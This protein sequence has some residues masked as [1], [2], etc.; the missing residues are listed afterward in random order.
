MQVDSFVIN[1]KLDARGD[2]TVPDKPEFQVVAE[3][4]FNTETRRA[5]NNNPAVT[6]EK[7]VEMLPIPKKEIPVIPTPNVTNTESNHLS[8]TFEPGYN[9][10]TI[11]GKFG[12]FKSR[13]NTI[14]FFDY[15]VVLVYT[16][17]TE[18]GDD[19][20]RFEPPIGKNF[21]LSVIMSDN[22][23]KVVTAR[24]IGCISDLGQGL[25][26]V[27]FFITADNDEDINDEFAEL[28]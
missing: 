25:K 9:Q 17:F 3:A 10:V 22:N 23:K 20:L 11:S 24:N 1:R 15:H 6:I 28:R 21:E 13:P 7:P 4:G 12:T 26:V 2:L 14:H 19:E 16:K 27:T 8:Y 18:C 5:A